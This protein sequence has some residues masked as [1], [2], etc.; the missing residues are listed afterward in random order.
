MTESCDV[1]DEL[2]AF[3]F[4]ACDRRDDVERHLRTCASCLDAFLAIKRDIELAETAA[5]PS[6]ALHALVR[7][8]VARAL[9][10]VPRPRRW[11]ERPVAF[12]F[13]VSVVLA[14]MVAM[15][16]LTTGPG[17]PPYAF[18]TRG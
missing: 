8:S 11:W 18:T 17:A 16:A 4:G 13:A 6:P 12:A 14:S 9:D 3:H 1:R 15:H 5:A 10:L 7:D 2:V